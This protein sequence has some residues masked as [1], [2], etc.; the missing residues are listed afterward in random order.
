[1]RLKSFN[2]LKAVSMRQRSL[3]R[4]LLKLN[5]CF[6]LEQFGMTGVVPCSSSSSR[7]SVLSYAVSPSMHFGGSTL[8]IKR[9]AMGQSCTSDPSH[10]LDL[11]WAK[12]EIGPVSE[13]SNADIL[14]VTEQSWFF[15][16]FAVEQSAA[17]HQSP[18]G[19]GG[20]SEPESAR[21]RTTASVAW[22]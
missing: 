5:G 17:H 6:L 16:R 11:C 22:V 21:T 14:S 8:W 13:M 2:L 9:S 3:Y 15:C 20:H 1:M 19:D 7:K 12:L 4:R 10:L 18:P